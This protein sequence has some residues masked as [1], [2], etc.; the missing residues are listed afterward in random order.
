MRNVV[1]SDWRENGAQ[2]LVTIYDDGRVT[3]ASRSQSWESWGPPSGDVV[4]DEGETPAF[5]IIHSEGMIPEAW[6]FS[7]EADAQA[8]WNEAIDSMAQPC[9]ADDPCSMGS[10]Q[11]ERGHPREDLYGSGF[12]T[13]GDRVEMRR[14]GF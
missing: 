5:V 12:V 2:H 10:C 8:A 6:T 4:V 1:L 14:E 9:T 3:V 13:D 11:A 7:T